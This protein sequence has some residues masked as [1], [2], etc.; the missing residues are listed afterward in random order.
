MTSTSPAG[1]SPNSPADFFRGALDVWRGLSYLAR[2]PGLWLWAMIPFLISVF[3][4]FLLG[5]GAWYLVG[6]WLHNQLF[7]ES[8]FWWTMLGWM[9]G[10][11]FWAVLALVA[12][13]LLRADR[14]IYRHALQ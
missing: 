2:Q 10:L 4:F 3:L 6:G 5:W 7:S 12:V 1:S 13:F 8:G 9:L 11:I 14:L